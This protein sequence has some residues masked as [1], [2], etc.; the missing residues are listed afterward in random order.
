MFTVR[1]EAFSRTANPAPSYVIIPFEIVKSFNL[2]H[3]MPTTG[4]DPVVIEA[5]VTKLDGNGLVDVTLT[6]LPTYTFVG[7]DVPSDMT[8]P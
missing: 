6:G 8:T 3:Y 2:G 5:P 4:Y 1:L 7:L